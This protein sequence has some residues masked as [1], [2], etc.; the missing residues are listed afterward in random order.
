MWTRSL[1]NILL[2]KF[3]TLFPASTGQFSLQELLKDE[4]NTPLLCTSSAYSVSKCTERFT[5]SA[6]QVRWISRIVLRKV[7]EHKHGTTSSMVPFPHLTP[8]L[9]PM[10]CMISQHILFSLMPWHYFPPFFLQQCPSNSEPKDKPEMERTKIF[11]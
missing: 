9:L 3:T 1:L 8:H 10:I 2:M 5:V 6:R 7:R 11:K 4:S